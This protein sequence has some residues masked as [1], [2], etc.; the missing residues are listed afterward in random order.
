[1][2][3]RTRRLELTPLRIDDAQEMAGVLDD[4]RLHEFIGGRPASAA[5]LRD[6][7]RRWIAGPGAPGRLWLNWIVRQRGD[8]VAVGTMQATI[9]LV[10]D[11]LWVADVAWV[12]GVRWQGRGFAS[13]AARAMVD[14]LIRHGIADVIAHVHP[15]HQ[16]SAAVARNAGLHPTG[17]HREDGEAL[18]RLTRP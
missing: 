18:W 10:D 7:Y 8:H 16:A 1:M 6:R 9:G 17:E 12:I 13:E 14:W 5:E 11:R 4:H 15:A 2:T 3:V